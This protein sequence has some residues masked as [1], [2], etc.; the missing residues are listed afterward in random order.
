MKIAVRNFG[1]IREAEIDLKPLTIFVGPN[2]MGKTWL[3][4][5]LAGI[6]GSHG[7]FGYL[8]DYEKEDA[9][10]IYPS[11]QR[12]VEQVINKGNATFDIYQFAKKSG[13]TYFN[14]V[15]QS[16]Q[17]WMTEYMST[18][19]ASFEE[20]SV[21][22]NLDETK[23]D[24]LE[25]ILRYSLR[26]EIA[27]A[28][29]KSRLTISKKR[30]DRRILAYTSTHYASSDDNL[31]EE[32]TEEQLPSEVIKEVLTREVFEIIHRAIY[33]NVRILPTERTTFIAYPPHIRSIDRGELLRIREQRSQQKVKTILGPVGYFL[34]MVQSTFE[35]ESAERVRREKDAKNNPK[36]REYIELAQL[37]ESQ[38]LGGEVD[39]FPSE[40]SFSQPSPQEEIYPTRDILFRPT[41]E[42]KLELSIA[43]SMVKELSPLLFYLRYLARPRELLVIDEPEMNL[44]PE[45]QVKMIE[46]LA[47]LINAGLNI[48][49]TTHSPYVIDH[50][51]NLIKA[52]E[53]EDK[54]RI[55]SE[56]YLQRSDAFISKE[57][58]SVYLFD[59]GQARKVIDEEG[60]ID[61]DTFGQVSDHI[62][63]IYFKL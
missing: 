22:I 6:F 2:N 26:A 55:C 60:V 34:A 7:H 54:E 28:D 15:A 20:L 48:L 35:D 37:L 21:S 44:H 18:E 32:P 41:L 58:V 61:L 5:A 9:S 53:A 16:V 63:E 52:Y 11:L 38:I 27:G 1:I 14:N 56:F 42:S 29:E 51:T 25:Q 62:S 57:S 23:T 12:A 13:E 45:A 24:F 43:S 31:S 4:Y 40:L 30:G 59:Q 49:I 8:E 46:F 33:R 36:I 50:L 47:I 39:F 10:T 17:R 19:L 3:A